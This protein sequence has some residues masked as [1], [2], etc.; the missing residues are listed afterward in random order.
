MFFEQIIGTKIKKKRLQIRFL[1]K[2]KAETNL[3]KKR[4]CL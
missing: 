1:S 3:F 2:V 4:L